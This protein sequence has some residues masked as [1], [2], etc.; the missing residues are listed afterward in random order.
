MQKIYLA[1]SFKRWYL[2]EFKKFL[3]RI[4]DYTYDAIDIK[5]Q[6]TLYK[7]L[8]EILLLSPSE[9]RSCAQQIKNY[10]IM[11][12]NEDKDYFENLYVKFRR[13][14]TGGKFIEKVA[15]NVCPYCNRNYIYNFNEDS[16]TKTTAQLDHFYDKSSYP[17]LAVSLYNLIPSC[18]TC[19]LR[20]SKKD[21]LEKP[22]L[23]PY[24][25]SFDDFAKFRL[26]GIKSLRKS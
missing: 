7:S 10:H 26:N 5:L 4:T 15:L 22:I 18:G 1:E 13:S 6:S 9:L 19:N 8:D 12:S 20:K 25:D 24:L 11:I 3:T 2:E 23:N 17:Y 21:T 14:I 16:S